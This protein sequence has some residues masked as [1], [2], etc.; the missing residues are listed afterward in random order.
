MLSSKWMRNLFRQSSEQ[1]SAQTVALI[2]S[3]VWAIAGQIKLDTWNAD[4]YRWIAE[5]DP[6][7]CSICKGLDNVLLTKN[8]LTLYPAHIACRCQIVPD[9]TG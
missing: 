7:T 3:G 1:I 2:G 6:K 9:N 4:S 5:A 8:E